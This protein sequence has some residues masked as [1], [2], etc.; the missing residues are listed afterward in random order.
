MILRLSYNQYIRYL[1]LQFE[2]YNICSMALYVYN[3]TKKLTT[4]SV[5]TA[6]R[7]IFKKPSVNP[8]L[9]L[10]LPSSAHICPVARAHANNQ[11]GKKGDT[12]GQAYTSNISIRFAFKDVRSCG[13]LSICSENGL[14]L[15]WKVYL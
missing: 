6:I 1:H 10:L 12:Q 11:G 8:K 9:E 15:T 4:M 3:S 2:F 13:P 7:L 5:P 14:P